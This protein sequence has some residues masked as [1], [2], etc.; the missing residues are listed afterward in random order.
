MQPE[1]TNLMEQLE[2][3]MLGWEALAEEAYK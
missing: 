2:E 3:I 1:F